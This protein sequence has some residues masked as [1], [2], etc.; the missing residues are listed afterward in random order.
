MSL[1]LL[2]YPCTNFDAEPV[3]G[4]LPQSDPPATLE[5][6]EKYP[7]RDVR[8]IGPNY[9]KRFVQAFGQVIFEVIS[10]ERD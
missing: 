8:G 7:I 4:K 3:Q 5:G 1:R 10:A 2:N 6:I 9:A